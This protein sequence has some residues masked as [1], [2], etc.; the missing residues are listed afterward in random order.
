MAGAATVGIA[1][2]TGTGTGTGSVKKR[3]TA[4][5]LGLG[6]LLVVGL[7][8]GGWLV[9]G[10]SGNDPAPK[11]KGPPQAVDAKLDW[12]APTPAV[13]QEKSDRFS[14]P[15]FTKDNIV[16]RT[17][18][19][20]TAYNAETGKPSWSIPVP[21]FSCT[22][23]PRQ[24][25]GIAAVVYGKEEFACDMVMAVDLEHGRALWNRELTDSRGRKDSFD[26]GN[27]SLARGVLTVADVLE[28]R[29]Y[30]A[31][32]GERRK[33]N[34]YGCRETGTVVKNDSEQLTIAQCQLF[35]RY[36][37]MNVDPRTGLEKWTWKV[38]DGLKV[39][40]VLSVNPAVIVVAREN[41][42]SPSDI[43]VLDDKGR[44]K[45]LISV[46]SGPYDFE[47]CKPRLL[48]SCRR[49]VVDGNTLYLP[50]SNDKKMTDGVFATTVVAIDLDTGKPRWTAGFDGNRD[51]RPVAMHDGRLLVYQ[52]PTRDES[53][54]LYSVDPATGKS[55]VF[56]RLPQESVAQEF[57]LARRG[58]TYFHDGRFFV[59]A[60]EGLT[61]R[62]MMMSFH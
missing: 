61:D 20:V 41:D 29:V 19:T 35:G 48:D 43:V 53:G 26:T 8:T 12:M 50:T 38:L 40:N 18:K 21:G 1:Q 14:T 51:Y 49:A 2:G 6:L 28:P 5:I 59:I 44:L 55:A 23:S 22:S 10:R 32:N 54:K 62:T 15:W 7:G 56:M 16:L 11:P 13:D 52:D 47:D 3:R 60:E 31:N 30:A 57:T 45:Q 17:R 34:D 46:S 4:V 25:A 27:L 36:F 33:P 58:T 42:T 39:Q 9:W 24:E 37:V